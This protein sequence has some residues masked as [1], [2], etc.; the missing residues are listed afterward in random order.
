[1]IREL[2]KTLQRE[3]KGQE[4]EGNVEARKNVRYLKPKT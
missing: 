3:H 1:M 2:Y 4:E